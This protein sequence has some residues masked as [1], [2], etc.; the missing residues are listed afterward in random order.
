MQVLTFPRAFTKFLAK[1]EHMQEL[2]F[3]HKT[4]KAW[5]DPYS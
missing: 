2:A 3:L 4:F 1:P 5:D